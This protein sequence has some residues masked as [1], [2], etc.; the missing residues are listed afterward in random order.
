MEIPY[1][2]KKPTELLQA[3]LLVSI[4]TIVGCLL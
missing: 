2:K 4:Q 3:A 1:G